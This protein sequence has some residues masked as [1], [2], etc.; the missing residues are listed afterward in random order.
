MHTHS[1]TLT[2]QMVTSSELC[3]IVTTDDNSFLVWGSRPVIKSPI[4]EVLEHSNTPKKIPPLNKCTSGDN[5]FSDADP[6]S[7]PGTPNTK[8]CLSQCQS[9]EPQNP[10]N[11]DPSDIP[12][13]SSGEASPTKGSA[14]DIVAKGLSP[15]QSSSRDSAPFLSRATARSGRN[16]SL[17]FSDS[18]HSLVPCS[19]CELYLRTLTEVVTDLLDVSLT[20]VRGGKSQSLKREST[21]GVIERA[22]LRL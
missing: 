16:P 9:L 12:I 15:Q 22:V 6:N 7:G 4:I 3:T 2:H 20:T 14:N 8:R 17:D 10:Q 1:L 19:D 11:S 13:P 18:P 21:S 5:V